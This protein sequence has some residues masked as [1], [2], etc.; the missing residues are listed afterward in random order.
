MEEKLNYIIEQ[1]D[2]YGRSFTLGVAL[3]IAIDEDRLTTDERDDILDNYI[4]PYYEELAAMMDQYR[5][6]KYNLK[7]WAEL[8]NIATLDEIARQITGEDEE[9]EEE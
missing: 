7:A 1:K 2:L 3:Y 5:L 6:D 8:L 4:L 9:D